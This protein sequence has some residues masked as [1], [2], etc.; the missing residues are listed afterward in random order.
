MGINNW[1]YDWGVNEWEKTGLVKLTTEHPDSVLKETKSN[2]TGGTDVAITS[3]GVDTNTIFLAPSGTTSF[4]KGK[5]PTITDASGTATKIEAPTATGSYHIYVMDV[6]GNVSSQ[7]KT[8]III[9]L[10]PEWYSPFINMGT[11]DETTNT[12]TLT[13]NTTIEIKQL[14]EIPLDETLT[15]PPTSTLINKH[16][17]IN[18]GTIKN[19]GNLN[20]LQGSLLNDGKIINGTG[21]T[22]N[23]MSEF[24]NRLA[25]PMQVAPSV[26][27]SRGATI[28]Y[29]DI[30]II[31]GVTKHPFEFINPATLINQ[32]TIIGAVQ[33]KPDTLHTN[34]ENSY[35]FVI[36]GSIGQGTWFKGVKTKYWFDTI[37]DKGT[38]DGTTNTFTLNDNISVEQELTIP[39]GELLLIPP[40]FTLTNKGTIRNNGTINNNAT[41]K[42]NNDKIINNTGTIN[43]NHLI[44]N[45]LNAKIDNTSGTINNNHLIYN[46]LN[47]KIDNTNGTINN[48]MLLPYGGVIYNAGTFTPGSQNTP[49]VRLF[50]E[51]ADEVLPTS[52]EVRDVF[53]VTIVSTGVP[54]NTIWLAPSGTIAF[55]NGSTIT[56][57]ITDA[58]GHA[59]TITAPT[60]RGTYH[61]YVMDVS[62]FISRQSTGVVTVFAPVTLRIANIDKTTNTLEKSVS[63]NVAKINNNVLLLDNNI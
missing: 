41:I 24:Q 17:I 13:M 49:N 6:S 37:K 21:A 47:A 14:L 50:S 39:L 62:G 33:P 12:F 22:I 34:K 36:T 46:H 15:I 53:D 32:G 29:G 26:T 19:N 40:T 52:K 5:G 3:S 44:Y 60:T 8:T 51:Q 4:V 23:S 27:N 45:H 59:T 9:I 1:N 30:I 54:G 35:I 20:H 63:F 38:Y 42:N 25:S 56:S 48:S 2:V 18:K 16:T 10:K 55:A 61:I 43:N 31:E 58:S 11:Y 28:I 7:S 57:T